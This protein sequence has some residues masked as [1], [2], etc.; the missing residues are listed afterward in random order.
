MDTYAVKVRQS[1]VR[2]SVRVR[3]H[4]HVHAYSVSVSV[5]RALQIL[6][7]DITIILLIP[8]ARARW[9]NNLKDL[10]HER[11]QAE[12]AEILGVF[13]FTRDLSIDTTFSPIHFARQ[14]P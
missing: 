1:C 5:Y 9:H 7:S 2:V 8:K 14:S 12:S 11:E 6:T 3:V 4:V 13:P 10:T